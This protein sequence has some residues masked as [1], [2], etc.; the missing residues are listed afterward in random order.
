MNLKTKV[1][2]YEVE[3]IQTIKKIVEID[4]E[5]DYD[6]HNKAKKIANVSNM[7]VNDYWIQ[8]GQM[9]P[10]KLSKPQISAHFDD[11]LKMI[12]NSNTPFK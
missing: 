5:N 4:A 6:C 10:D 1:M 7:E 9:E 12:V 11:A 8:D 2:I 3:L